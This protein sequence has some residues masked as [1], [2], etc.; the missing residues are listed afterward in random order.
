MPVLNSGG[1]EQVGASPG[2]GET[3]LAKDC[4]LEPQGEEVKMKA[5]SGPGVWQSGGFWQ[6]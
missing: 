2:T 5:E 1:L 6:S 3:H 4:W